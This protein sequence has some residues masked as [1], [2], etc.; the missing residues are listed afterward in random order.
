MHVLASH[1][2]SEVCQMCDCIAVMEGDTVTHELHF[3]IPGRTMPT[4][5]LPA[6]FGRQSPR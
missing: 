6:A 1:G 4:A 5:L 2:L 3:R